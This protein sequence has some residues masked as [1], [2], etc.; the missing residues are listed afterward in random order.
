LTA[1]LHHLANDSFNGMSMD[2]IAETAGVSKPTIYRRW[3]SKID[4]AAAAV[5]SL[6]LN[7]PST[8][9]L[10]VWEALTQEIKLASKALARP[11]GMRLLSTLLAHESNEPEMIRKFREGVITARRSRILKVLERAKKEGLL[12]PE[13]DSVFILNMI[14]GYYYSCWI[15]GQ[16]MQEDWPERCVALVQRLSKSTDATSD[17]PKNVG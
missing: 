13:T 5:A 10:E 2:D 17:E 15:A 3:P 1:A 4:M 11:N 14:L 16:P 9:H 7:D 6:A 8:A 12:A